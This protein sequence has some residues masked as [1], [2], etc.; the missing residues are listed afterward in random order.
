MELKFD[1]TNVNNLPPELQPTAA[2]RQAF[3]GQM[4]FQQGDAADS[5]FVVKRGRVK[6]ARYI[7]EDR[8]TTLRVARAG[9]GFG[10]VGL[11]LDAYPYAAIAE[12]PS[13]VIRYPKA[14]L[15]TALPA[16]PDLAETLLT[17]LIQAIRSFEIR[18]ELRDIRASHQ[19]VLRYLRYQIQGDDE[20]V[21]TLDRP[22]KDIAADL[23]FTPETLSRALTRLEQEGLISRQ[24]RQ[25]TLHPAA[26]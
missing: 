24:D 14:A 19:R 20:G 9:E 22:L 6:L 17:M 1:L 8:V 15:V 26:A 2:V 25:I 23:G 12:V 10:A 13:Q 5:F 4:L 7:D 11:I 3:A 21:I 16:Y 18:L